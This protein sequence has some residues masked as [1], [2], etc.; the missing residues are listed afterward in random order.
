MNR[1]SAAPLGSIQFLLVWL[2]SGLALSAISGRWKLVAVPLIGLGGGA[3][4]SL[5][6]TVVCHPEK[7]ARSILLGVCATISTILCLLPIP[8]VQHGAVRSASA[9]L[10]A[11][12]IILAISILSGP[13]DWTDVWARLWVSWDP[14]WGTGMEKGLS[15]AFVGLALVG[16]AVDWLLK[17]QFGECPD[18]VCDT[19]L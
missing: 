12:G 3:A 19:R 14:S 16:M 10:G 17:R 11:L 7:L 1:T 5:F 2:L 4:F 8:K 18:E 6:V 9:W 15:A 13:S